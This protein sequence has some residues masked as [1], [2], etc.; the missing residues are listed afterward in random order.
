[1]AISVKLEYCGP[2]LPRQEHYYQYKYDLIID[3]NGKA[4]SIRCES[5]ERIRN[6]MYTTPELDEEM[7]KLVVKYVTFLGWAAD[8]LARG[9]TWR[10]TYMPPTYKIDGR[11]YLFHNPRVINPVNLE[12]YGR[13][14]EKYND[15]RKYFN[16]EM[17]APRESMDECEDHKTWLSSLTHEDADLML[18]IS[19]S[20]VELEY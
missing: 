17:L 14:E 2:L 5:M 18:S 10:A 6:Y 7:R 4:I 12:V 13:D 9:G 16:Y 3:V 8:Q 19:S 20:M 1:M 15:F 11:H